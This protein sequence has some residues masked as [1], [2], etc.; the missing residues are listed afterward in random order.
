MKRLW[1][2]L[3][4]MAIPGI[5]LMGTLSVAAAEEHGT[6]VA[7]ATATAYLYVLIIQVMYAKGYVIRFL[8]DS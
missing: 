4:W 3:Y 2:V 7:L 8:K 1:R 5:V 6:M